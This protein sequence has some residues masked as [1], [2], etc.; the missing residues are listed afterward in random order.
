MRRAAIF[1]QRGAKSFIFARASVSK[2][3]RDSDDHFDP[4]FSFMAMRSTGFET[5]GVQGS[6]NCINCG[7][8]GRSPLFC[9]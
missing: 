1:L 6:G 2:K 9:R 5:F 3:I 8:E 7:I 4:Q